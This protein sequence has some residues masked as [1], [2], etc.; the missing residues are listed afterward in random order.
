MNAPA[1][2][3]LAGIAAAAALGGLW[4]ARDPL[5]EAV[6][7][8]EDAAR[9]SPPF[10]APP[11]TRAGLQAALGNRNVSAMLATIRHAEGTLG[12]NG[13]RMLFGGELFESFADHPRKVVVRLSRG[14]PL[15]STAAGAYQ[16]LART[17]DGLRSALQLP[18]FGP[19]SQDLAAVELIRRR[20]ALEL[21]RAGRFDAALER[22]RREWASLPGAGYGQPEKSRT[23]LAAVY[24]TAGGVIA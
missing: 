24:M 15:K 17:W 8:D 21:L 16:I 22:M 11:E 7:I 6:A 4:A 14:R 5:L 12:A 20:G 13:Y 9:V 1:P 3:L 10:N 23:E 18:D 19:R 2:A